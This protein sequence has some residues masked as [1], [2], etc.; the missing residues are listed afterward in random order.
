MNRRDVMLPV[1][2]VVRVGENGL[3][4]KSDKGSLLAEREQAVAPTNKRMQILQGFLT[5][6]VTVA[7]FKLIAL[8]PLGWNQQLAVK[9]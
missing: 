4:G 8:R 6:L 1:F 3:S 2:V 9:P 5:A 7:A